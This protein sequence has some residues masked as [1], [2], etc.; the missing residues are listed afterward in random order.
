MSA[1]AA[2]GFHS[3]GKLVWDLI[4]PVSNSLDF[5]KRLELTILNPPSYWGRLY[6]DPAS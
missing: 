1:F 2:A 3:K 4:K 6:S 5:N